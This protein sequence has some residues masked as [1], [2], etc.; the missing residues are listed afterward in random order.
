MDTATV[1]GH[2]YTG[3]IR[4][5][6]VNTL[7]PEDTARIYRQTGAVVHCWRQDNPAWTL[8]DALM[9]ANKRQPLIDGTVR[10]YERRYYDAQPALPDELYDNRCLWLPSRSAHLGIGKG[11]YLVVYID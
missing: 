5:E 2:E 6:H 10:V 4:P 7:L 11:G 1:Y 9:E 3:R 8:A